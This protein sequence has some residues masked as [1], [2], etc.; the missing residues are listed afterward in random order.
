MAYLFNKVAKGHKLSKA[1][2]LPV[3][4]K[5]RDWLRDIAQRA[6]RT[7]FKNTHAKNEEP[8]KRLQSLSDNS[9]GKMYTFVYD[10]K[11]KDDL[12]YYDIYP[13]IFP[14]EY[15]GDSM[16]GINMH[17]LPPILRAQLMDA[18]Y[19]T[20]NNEKYNKTTRLQISY[21]IL[22]GAAAYGYFKPCVKKYLFSHVRS[23]FV[24]ISPDEWDIALMLP[25]QQFKKA[26]AEKVWTDSRNKF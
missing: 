20:L 7:S 4:Q 18:L 14:I 8:F 17:Y 13:L 24:Y 1:E 15:Y 22:K 10:P 26:S 6:Q 9:I 25:T 23:Q 21:K 5:T 19:H 2:R 12:P 11:W 3:D 16:L